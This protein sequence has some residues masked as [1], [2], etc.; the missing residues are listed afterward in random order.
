MLVAAGVDADRLTH[1]GSG[2]DTSVDK[3]SGGARQLVRRV[4][5]KLK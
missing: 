5:F 4:T 3:S 1:T 2:E